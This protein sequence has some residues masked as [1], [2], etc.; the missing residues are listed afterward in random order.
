[1][2]LSLLT[3]LLQAHPDKQFRLI[4]PSRDAVPVSFHITE[5]AHVQKRFLDCGGALHT[6][7][8]CQLQAWVHTDTDHRL[9]AGKMA[10]VLGLAQK[11]LPENQDLDIEIEYEDTAI[12]Q[13]PVAD[14]AVTD[15]EVILS[16]T[17]KHT[18]CLAKAVCLP[19]LPMAS[20]AGCG[21]GP[22]CCG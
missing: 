11:V 6:T 1:M 20:G 7:N 3:S 19:Q 17:A 10:G 4:L 5:V 9:L 18:D 13:Y 22:S 15:S 14:Y 8:T 12:S 21:C 16:L 2:K